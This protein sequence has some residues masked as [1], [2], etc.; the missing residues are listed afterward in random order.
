MSKVYKVISKLFLFASSQIVFFLQN[1][2]CRK[3]PF[4]YLKNDENKRVEL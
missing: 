2:K 4:E 3:N 1:Q